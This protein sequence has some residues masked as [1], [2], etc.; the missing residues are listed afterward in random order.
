MPTSGAAV[1][2]NS[3]A[4]NGSGEGGGASASSL[5]KNCSQCCT[6][7]VLGTFT[8][9]KDSAHPVP[10]AFH[11][12]FKL[13]ALFIYLVGGIF[14]DHNFVFV[15]VVCIL[16]LCSDF[17]VVK[18]V[19]GRLLVGLRWWNKI[20]P[21][22]STEWIYESAISSDHV[23]KS[24]SNYFWTVLYVTPLIW[25]G[26]FIVGL[27]KFNIG[28]LL[29]VS[30]ALVLNGSNLYGYW[31]CSKDQK[32]KLKDMMTAGALGA[33]QQVFFGGFGGA[34]TSNAQQQ[35]QTQQQQYPSAPPS[36]FVV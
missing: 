16:L 15:A 24:D 18:N 36:S 22:G 25:G 21:D 33:A 29:I 19:T 35:T 1:T 23:R 8:F 2:I 13:S 27:L 28:W 30:C 14:T 31:M 9:L 6:N 4:S 26:L 3:A 10:A 17:W 12:I 32:Q 20:N 11:I 7:C 34:G 5:L